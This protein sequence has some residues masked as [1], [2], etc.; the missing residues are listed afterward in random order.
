[1]P[2]LAVGALDFRRPKKPPP[3]PAWGA[4]KPRSFS[5][6]AAWPGKSGSGRYESKLACSNCRGGVRLATISAPLTV[7]TRSVR[8]RN[9]VGTE[10]VVTANLWL[11]MGAGVTASDASVRFG[12]ADGVLSKGQ[13]S[14]LDARHPSPTAASCTTGG[15]H[16]RRRRFDLDQVHRLRP[17]RA[18]RHGG[19]ARSAPG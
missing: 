10:G 11:C 18:P 16:D 12:G 5:T 9:P 19:V 7:G 2:G 8:L 13:A 14:S 1:M 17:P 3:P 15:T 6:A 4:K